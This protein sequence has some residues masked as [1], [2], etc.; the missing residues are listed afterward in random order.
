MMQGSM[1]LA[2]RAAQLTKATH[3][4]GRIS[5][6]CQGTVSIAADFCLYKIANDS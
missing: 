6:G 5:L 4:A 2:S 1:A 3:S